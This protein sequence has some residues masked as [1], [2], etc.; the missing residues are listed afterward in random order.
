MRNSIEFEVYG[1]YALFTDPLTKM[2]VKNYPTKYLPTK[3]SKE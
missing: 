1:K 2:G 3:R